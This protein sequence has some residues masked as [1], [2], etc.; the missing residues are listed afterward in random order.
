MYCTALTT[1]VVFLIN[2]ILSLVDLSAANSLCKPLDVSSLIVPQISS[3]LTGLHLLDARNTVSGDQVRWWNL[4]HRLDEMEAENDLE[5]NF[6]DVMAFG[7]S[8]AVGINCLHE[9]VT[10]SACSYP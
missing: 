5:H 6:I 9:N 4:L 2:I 3:L 10:R 7:G 8:M 1:N